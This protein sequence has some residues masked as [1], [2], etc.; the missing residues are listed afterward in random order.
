MKKKGFGAGRYNGFGGKVNPGEEVKAAALREMHEEASIVIHPDDAQKVATLNFSFSKQ[1]DFNQQVHVFVSRIWS[2]V[3]IESDEM[4]PEW[5]STKDIPFHQ[6]WVDDKHWVP[7]VLE[8]HKLEASFTFGETD[9]S[10]LDMD[11][12]KL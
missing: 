1:P 10:I 8:G 2:G 4:K 9:N 3:P 7:L 6:M 5:F 12:K 11:I